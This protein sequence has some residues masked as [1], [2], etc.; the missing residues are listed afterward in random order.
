M[1]LAQSQTRSTN[2]RNVQTSSR[3]AALHKASA[4]CHVVVISTCSKGRD[5]LI[6]LTAPYRPTEMKVSETS[7]LGGRSRRELSPEAVTHE[8]AKVYGPARRL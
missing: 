5:D 8:I 2:S 3:V 6:I 7:R 1:H 4:H